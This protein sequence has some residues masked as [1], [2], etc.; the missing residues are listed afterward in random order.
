VTVTSRT[1]AKPRMTGAERREQILDVTRDLAADRGFHALS[2][3]AV[4][5]EA[6]ITRPVIYGHFDDLDG[7]LTALIDRESVRA[8]DQ[9]AQVLPR[10]D[11]AKT[12]TDVF[13]AGLAGYLDVVQRDPATWRLLLMPV[14]GTP[15]VLQDRIREGRDVAVSQISAAIRD[16]RLLGDDLPDPELTAKMLSA[17]SDESAKLVLTDPENY[18]VD[19]ILEHARWLLRRLAA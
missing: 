15:E 13:V 11:G 9:L 4:A 18:P 5:R 14:E 16:A 8:F 6:G 10:V 1:P 19:R 3:E 17:L 2:I 7:L 12:A